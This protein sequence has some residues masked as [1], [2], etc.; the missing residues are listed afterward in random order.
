MGNQALKT[1]VLIIGGGATGTG[2]FRD[3]ALRG[4]NCILV[5][6][7]DLNAGASG[8]NHGL[9]HSGGR[10]V[11]ND[12]SSARECKEEGDILKKLAPQLI[13]NTGGIFV[14]VEG[15][16]EKFVADYPTYCEQSG[17]PCKKIS[18]AEARELEPVISEKAIAAYLVEDASIDPFKLALENVSQARSLGSTLLRRTK[19]VGFEISNREITL[20]RLQ[21]TET[22]E[23]VLIEAEQI[24]NAAGAWAAE[25]AALAKAEINVVYSK[26]TL[27]ISNDRITTRIVNRLRPPSNADILVPGGTVSVLGTTSTTIKDLNNVYPTIEEADE[28]V[29]E[30][31]AM[32]PMLEQIRY[33]RAFSGVRPL[34][35]SRSGDAR[36]LSRGFSLLDHD[37]DDLDNFITITGGKLT[38]YRMMAERTADMV[39]KRLGNT[40]PC[41]TAV[42][43]LPM[44]DDCEWTEPALSPRQWMRKHDP[45]DVLFCDCEMVSKK[46]I[47]EIIESLYKNNEEPKIVDIG[48]RSRVGRGSC[49][50]AFCG[51]RIAAYLYERKHMKDEQGLKDL[52]L[53]FRE[54]WK[55]IDSILWGDQMVQAE[56]M[57][58]MHCGLFGHDLYG[59]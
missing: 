11:S 15:D 25:V 12:Q 13:D 3:L 20:A 28:I 17:V 22:G 53:F 59:E 18:V 35:G 24:V 49:Q 1:Q 21:N 7:D 10:Y 57:E 37:E 48:F 42:E 54:R 43:P 55:G 56:L 31:A 47:D 27:L 34:V 26:G 2:I 9:L 58:A 33:I 5:E 14:A 39:C 30:S 38:T 45:D 16:D 50:G 41:L 19:V 8:G 4:V 51:A 6:Q 46:A 32:I 44:I 23:E 36:S 52:V 40:R 29:S